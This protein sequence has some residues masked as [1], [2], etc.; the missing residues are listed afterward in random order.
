MGSERKYTI[1]WYWRR[2]RCYIYS[3]RLWHIYWICISKIWYGTKG[4]GYKNRISNRKYAYNHWQNKRTSSWTC[5]YRNFRIKFWNAFENYFRNKGIYQKS[6]YIFSNTT[7]IEWCCDK[8]EGDTH[9]FNPWSP[10]LLLTDEH[11]QSTARP[12][13][14]CR[15][16]LWRRRLCRKTWK[17]TSR[18]RAAAWAG[19]AAGRRK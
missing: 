19:S 15:I 18:K 16:G 2:Y 8:K 1:K 13:R 12:N 4:W 3:R 5:N 9:L 10:I 17:R 11:M 14:K 7:G 6:T